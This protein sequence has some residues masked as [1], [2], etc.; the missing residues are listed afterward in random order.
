MKYLLALDIG[1]TSVKAGLF[2]ASGK[3]LATAVEEYNLLTPSAEKVELDPENYWTASCNILKSVIRS[4]QSDSSGVV[5]ITVSSQGETIICVDEN[6]K[7]VRNA[8]VWMDN[9]ATTQA[10]FL[11]GILGV[12]AYETTGIPDVIP[13]WPACKILWIKQ[14]EPENFARTNKFL[15]VQDYL[16]YRLTGRYITDGSIS[17]TSLL[18]DIVNHDWWQRSLDAIGITPHKLPAIQQAGT[19]AGTLTTEAATALGL[20]ASVA[21]VCG[22]MDQS[23]GAIGAGNIA[24]GIVS[25][26]T[27]AAL[28]I[29]AAVRNPMIDPTRRTPVYVHSIPN[30]YLFVP[31]CPTAGMAFKWFKD[32]FI[33]PEFIKQGDTVPGDVYELMNQMA[34]QVPAGCDGL[35]M[36]PHLMGVFSPESNPS[37]RGSFTG[38]TL[39]HTRAHFVRAIQEAVAY[40]LRQNIEAMQKAGVT[41]KE[42]RATGGAAKSAV[43]NQI[44]ADVCGVPIVRLVNED[45][46]IVG[47]AILGG[48]AMG[49]FPTIE[50]ACQTMV[51]TISSIS[52]SPYTQEYNLHYQRYINLNNSLREYFIQNYPG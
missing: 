2:N 28:T 30:G 50:A 5:A 39:L 35:V 41:V 15:L 40:M 32:N 23:V 10:V 17:C 47:D 16:I 25:E 7:P 14:N 29:Q 51:Q 27:G 12:D 22:G 21:V 33:L 19:I 46:G 26:T 36:L 38:F 13:T 44:K 48:V 52:P 4:V 43:W 42:I 45:T 6:G 49:L 20:S 1:T 34:E 24:E 8:I 18:F 9:R 11:A 31:V 3:C 37:A